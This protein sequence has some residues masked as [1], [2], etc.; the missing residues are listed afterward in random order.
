MKE[1]FI[2]RRFR[3]DALTMIERAN[4]IIEEDQDQDFTLTLRQ[5]YYQF[6]A[7]DLLANT[8]D[9]YKLLGRTMVNARDAGLVDWDAIED[10]SREVNTHSVFSDPAEIIAAAA[11]Q[12]REDLWEGQVHCPEVWIEKDS[13]I[14]VIEGVCT[15]YRVPYFA[16]RGSASSTAKYQAGKRFAAQLGLGHTPVVLYLGDHDPTGIDITRD[17]AES[18][19]LY[20]G[21]LVEVRRLA[22]NMDQVRRHRPP[23]NPA[24]ESDANF[25]KYV[26]EFGTTKC[27]E[28]DALSPDV[29]AGLV[30]QEIEALIE[31]RPWKLAK[32]KEEDNRR[33][34]SA[35]ADD[36]ETIAARLRKK[37]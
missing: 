25:N 10:R 12:Y 17:T 34:I 2:E 27:W 29:I 36:W 16:Q 33:T 3:G 26:A 30:E 24:K 6:V 31:Q 7:R 28:L 4:A 37:R 22:L 11:M 9:N 19:M 21:Q 1:K 15:K 35:V 23:P 32:A 14:G 20:A 18:L 8:M 13:L 5:L